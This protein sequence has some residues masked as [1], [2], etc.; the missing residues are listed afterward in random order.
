MV[1]PPWKAVWRFSKKLRVELIYD[2][3]IQP[4]GMLCYAQMV[5]CVLLF[6]TLWTVAHEAPLYMGFSRQ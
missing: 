6:V 2:P 5:S 4:C 1:Q 3:A